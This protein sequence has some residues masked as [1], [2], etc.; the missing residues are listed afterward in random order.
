[1]D[2]IIY[3]YG[4]LPAYRKAFFT[5]LSAE[6]LEDNIDMQVFYGENVNKLTRQADDCNFKT[7]K[8]KTKILDLK[9]LRLVRMCGLYK[10]IKKENPQAVIFQFNPTNLSEWLVLFYCKCRKIPYGVWG[11]NYT[12]SDLAK[13]LVGIRKRLY[14]IIYRR[15]ACMIPYGTLFRDYLEKIGVPKEK[16]VVAQNTIDVES[17]VEQTGN[18][19]RTFGNQ[20]KILYVGALSSQKRVE[21]SIDAVANLINEGLDVTYDIVGGGASMQSIKEYLSAKNK[22]VQN[23]IILHG[24]K[25]GKDLQQFFLNSD[26]FLMP[27]SGG[28]GVNEA[29]AY[30]LPIISTLGDETIY[31]LL[32][33]N[34]FLLPSMGIVEEQMSAIKAFIKVAKEQKMEMSVLSQRLILERASLKNMV[35]SHVRACKLLLKRK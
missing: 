32:D 16:I 11:C 17:I 22:L 5:K 33:G 26:V 7:T 10:Q 24:P 8:F 14:D 4:N 12:R 25:Y 6:L 28:L 3:V 27:G 20:L 21:S 15:S 34:G 23:R 30:G 13:S 1:M 35:I 19:K 31:D 18:H 9:L 29:M 2:K